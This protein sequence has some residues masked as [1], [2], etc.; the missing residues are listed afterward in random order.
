MLPLGLPFYS[1]GIPHSREMQ[2]KQN[3]CTFTDDTFF[4]AAIYGQKVEALKWLKANECP[5]G[6][7]SIKVA[8]QMG[9]NSDVVSWLEENG[10]PE[11]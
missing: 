8:H 11:K 5:W 7:L 2:C 4:Y 3:G 1:E 9:A 10:C 6:I